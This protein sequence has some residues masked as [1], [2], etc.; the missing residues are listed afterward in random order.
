MKYKWLY[1]GLIFSIM[2][3]LVPVSALAYTNTPHNWGIPRP[4]K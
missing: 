1:I 2:M 3:A 4:K